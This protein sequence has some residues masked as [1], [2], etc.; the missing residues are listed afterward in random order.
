MDIQQGALSQLGQGAQPQLLPGRPVSALSQMQQMLMAR[1]GVQQQNSINNI[2]DLQTQRNSVDMSAVDEAYDRAYPGAQPSLLSSFAA[3]VRGSGAFPGS[4]P[5][6]GTLLGTATGLD[7]QD[8]VMSAQD[9]ERALMQAK[10]AERGASN[11]NKSINADI[12]AEVDILKASKLAAGLG[13]LGSSGTMDHTKWTA[14]NFANMLKKNMDMLAKS[15]S[16]LS[17]QELQAL[18]LR[19]TQHQ[20]AVAEGTEEAD[21]SSTTG[22]EGGDRVLP[23][24]ISLTAPD[25]VEQAGSS[26][27]ASGTAK[28]FLTNYENNYQLPASHAN[29]IISMTDS[30]KNLA[31]VTGTGAEAMKWLGNALGTIGVDGSLVSNAANLTEAKALLTRAMNT[32]LLMEKGV[33]TASDEQRFRDELAK[34]TDPKAVFEFMN[35][36]SKEIALRSLEKS[37][38]GSQYVGLVGEKK[39]RPMEMDSNWQTV[40]NSMG[41]SFQNVGGRPMFRHQWIDGF[42]ARY[43]NKPEYKEDP[44]QLYIDAERNWLKY[45]KENNSGR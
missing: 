25:P 15:R 30:I 35:N 17:G 40:F 23:E 34:I 42:K 1:Q 39:A 27:M 5:L 28:S 10:L 21:L 24:G 12:N 33:Q 29:E 45:A 31:P 19:L 38:F 13:G 11:K 22:S 18:A 7:Y 41:P 16:E 6:M 44:G 8:K 4:K 3:G 26:A 32:R 9:R 14:T 37:N 2:R 43:G 20:Q 36:Y